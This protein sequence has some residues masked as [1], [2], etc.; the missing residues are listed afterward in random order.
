MR[1]WLSRNWPWVLAGTLLVVWLLPHW[2]EARPGGG[3][4]FS[5]GSSSFSG[6]GSSDS[7][8]D[9]LFWIVWLCIEHPVIGIPLLIL[10][11]FVKWKT[12]G[13]GNVQKQRWDSAPPHPPREK[14][15]SLQPLRQI[16]PEFSRVLFEDFAYKLYARAHECRHSPQELS[17]LAPYLEP[18]ARQ[19]LA[20]RKPSAPMRGVVVGSM[21]VVRTQI[22]RPQAGQESQ[23]FA[24]IAVAFVANMSGPQHTW[25]V[26]EVW[27]FRRAL[28][29][30]TPP[31]DRI[32]DFHCPSCGAPFESGDEV[33][34]GSCRQEVTGG[35]FD[36]T[37]ESIVETQRQAKPPALAGHAQEAGTSWPTV[38]DPGFAAAHQ[39]LAAEDPQFS[40][41]ALGARLQLIYKELNQAWSARKL[42]PIRPFVSDSMYHYLGYWTKAYHKAHLQ[43]RL[44]DMRILRWTG[45]KLIR[46]KHY[47]AL[48]VR[49]WATGKD[50]T[51]DLKTGQVTGGSQTVE[52][53]YS[54]Y[55]TLIRSASVRG[56][57]RSDAN[58]PNC[59]APLKVNMAGRCEFCGSHMTRGEF[60]WVLSKIEQ[61]EVYQG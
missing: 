23:Q 28:S 41:E 61:D 57:A 24:Q 52:R 22:P 53:T 50:F 14:N 5:G 58:C 35:R 54:E 51:V 34:C 29:A 33:T 56:A 42:A 17:R 2:A 20:M 43:N 10:F 30:E 32:G 44:E 7:D 49:L 11:I 45:V 40:D 46:D 13:R 4:S 18:R 60:D 6:G 26:K 59:G 47:D 1:R 37:V 38:T 25:F 12:R 55:W 9:L 19:A 48:T 15:L 31:P 3:Q 27:V 21:A 8:G 16:D 39:R 36:W